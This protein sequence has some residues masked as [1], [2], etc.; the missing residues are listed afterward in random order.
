MTEPEAPSVSRRTVVGAAWA[1]PVIVSLAAAPQAAASAD[2]TLGVFP[3]GPYLAGSPSGTSYLVNV[4]NDG[5]STIPAGALTLYVDSLYKPWTWVLF[6]G[7]GWD[8][9]SGGAGGPT[10]TYVCT[11]PLAPSETTWM[12]IVVS[13]SPSATSQPT[14]QLTYSAVGYESNI[15]SIQVPY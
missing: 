5:L 9:G 7:E 10:Y 1:A 2:Q 12:D 6:S 4:R 3:I 15:V 8:Y 11:A 13:R 14:A